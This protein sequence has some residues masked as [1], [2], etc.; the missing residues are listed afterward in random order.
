MER[1]FGMATFYRSGYLPTTPLTLAVCS[2]VY[3]AGDG[4]GD[5]TLRLH[6]EDPARLP[7]QIE[8]ILRIIETS[9]MLP[10]AA[11]PV[12]DKMQSS[13]TVHQTLVV[14]PHRET[15]LVDDPRL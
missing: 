12:T 2:A 8:A 4:M 9:T 15:R 3:L 14:M 1:R 11:P 13:W 7:C 6:L 10:C 5:T